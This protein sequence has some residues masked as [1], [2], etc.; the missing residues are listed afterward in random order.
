VAE[1]EKNAGNLAEIDALTRAYDEK[2]EAF[3]EVKKHIDVLLKDAK[4]FG[5]EELSLGEKKKHLAAKQKKLK[6]MLSEVSS[7]ISTWIYN[8]LT[9]W[10]S[11]ESPC[12]IRSGTSVRK[13][14]GRD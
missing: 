2:L 10:L 4:K 3:D 12:P 9:Q 11:S 14:R 8:L 5:K 7:A 6:K 13:S 1:Q